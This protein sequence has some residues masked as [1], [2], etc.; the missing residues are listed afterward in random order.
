[1]PSST[2]RRHALL[3]ISSALMGAN[4]WAADPAAT[5]Y[6]QRNITL[7][8][9]LSAGSDTDILA[10]LLAERMSRLLGQAIVVDNKTGAGGQIANQAL[11]AAK[12]DGYTLSLTFQATLALLPHL[13]LKKPYDPIKDFTPVGLFA[14]TGNALLVSATSPAQTFPELI[15]RAKAT[16]GKLTFG[17]WGIGSG[18]HLQGEFLKT[19]TGIDIV[20]VPFRGTSDSLLALLKGEIDMMFAGY[21]LASAQVQNG[22]V[23]AL[24]VTARQ[25]GP[26][27]PAV[28][29][30]SELGVPY[31]LDGWFGL[32][33]PAGMP[34]DIVTK[35]NATLGAVC[36]QPDL[37]ERIGAM[38][39]QLAPNSPTEFA[40]LIAKDYQAWG[41]IVKAAQ[42]PL[43]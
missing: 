31:A 20:H 9:P 28:P 16:P 17:S 36:K 1:M 6:P 10:R 25:R 14:T 18:G 43:E 26:T 41:A 11:A 38:G 22:K 39:M 21:G 23:R 15:A 33:G 8:A 40:A 30:L 35:L 19:L 5:N 37:A 32:I 13:K 27:L 29:T 2:S 24:A 7:I 34:S 4:A 3:G 42:V 12:P